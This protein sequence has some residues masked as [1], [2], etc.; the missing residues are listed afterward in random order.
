MPPTHAFS[1]FIDRAASGIVNFAGRPA[2]VFTIFLFVF[3]W[4]VAGLF[5]DFS[6]R[7]ELFMGTASSAIT[8]LMV[9][10]ILKAQNKDS[11]SIQLK[12]NELVAS[13]DQASNRLV[14]VEGMTED[15]LKVIRK[16]YSRLSEFARQQDTLQESHS[17]DEVHEDH[18][19]K[20]EMEDE[21]K[22]MQKPEEL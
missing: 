7:W 2:S 1:Q 19:I 5:V 10:L 15:E 14:N 12:L 8:I 17:I 9:F 20:K 16:Y 21:L 13:N 11:I 18:E 22:D 3:A 6:A 4:A